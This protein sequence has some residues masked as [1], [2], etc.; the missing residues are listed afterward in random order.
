MTAGWNSWRRRLA[1]AFVT[2]IA[3][4]SFAGLRAAASQSATDPAATASRAATERVVDF[5]YRPTPLTVSAG[6]RVVFSNQ[7]RTAHTATQ[8]GG[9]FDT[10]RIRPGKAASVTFKRRGTFLF[11]CTIHPFMH[12]RIVVR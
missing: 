12:G 1:L 6:T 3:L 5:A 10:G 7:G 8:N 11:H 9:G 4:A 2:A